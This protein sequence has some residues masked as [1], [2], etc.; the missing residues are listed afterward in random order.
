MKRHKREEWPGLVARWEASGQSA[1][2][3]ASEIGVD[4]GTLGRWKRAV[5]PDTVERRKPSLT[6]IVEIRADRPP[7]DDR[8]EVR[9]GGGRSVAVPTSFDPKALERLLQLLEAAT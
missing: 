2:E 6:K 3:F 4:V 9:L 1:A 8:F 5:A 7:A